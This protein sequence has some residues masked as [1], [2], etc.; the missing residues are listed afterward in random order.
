MVHMRLKSKTMHVVVWS[1][2]SVK[3]R[4]GGLGMRLMQR[5]GLGMRLMQCDSLGMRLKE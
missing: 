4:C 2:M 3:S 5:G 1:E